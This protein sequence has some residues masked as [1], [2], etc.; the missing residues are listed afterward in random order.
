MHLYILSSSIAAASNAKFI[1]YDA[2]NRGVLD[3]AGTWTMV[4]KQGFPKDGTFFISIGG[5]TAE[6]S[7][8]LKTMFLLIIIIEKNGVLKTYGIIGV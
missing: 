3:T 1:G 6:K 2:T 7:I 5:R 4:L 8:L